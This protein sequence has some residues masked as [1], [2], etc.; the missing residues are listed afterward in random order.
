MD[1]VDTTI[2]Q[3]SRL[4]IMLINEPRIGLDGEPE[5]EPGLVDLIRGLVTKWCLK[6]MGRHPARPP[7]GG[8]HE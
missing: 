3:G 2:R 4:Q 1:Q 6:S 5:A 7:S 8:V